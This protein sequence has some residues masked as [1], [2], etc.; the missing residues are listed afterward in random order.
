MRARTFFRE[1]IA[2]QQQLE[3]KLDCPVIS[4]FTD[5]FIDYQYFFDT[6][7]HL[8]DEGTRI[9]TQLLADDLRKYMDSHMS[10]QHL[11]L[12]QSH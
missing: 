4:D 11:S 10:E 3:S 2:F 1:Y 12:T 8:T 9:R 6:A 5:Y 7:F